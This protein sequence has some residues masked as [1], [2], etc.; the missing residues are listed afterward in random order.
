LYDAQT[1]ERPPI[2][3]EDEAGAHVVDNA[4]RFQPLQIAERSGDI[5]NPVH[6]NLEEQIA[7][8]GWDVDQRVVAPGDTLRLSLFWKCQSRMKRDYT[9]STQV[10][11]VAHRKVA[12]S[13]EPP[14]GMSTKE[15]H[16]G[17]QVVDVRELTIDARAPA[18]GYDILVSAY[19]WAPSGELVR[20]R[21]IDAE[22]RVLPRDSVTLG[23]IRVR[24]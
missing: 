24:E 2:S 22:G 23:K 13:D 16:V 9:V 18:G 8:V 1:G 5:P 3:V 21:V 6:K 11:D 4:L 15:C 14:G 10:V 17:Q 12:Q 20:L 7:L 19:D